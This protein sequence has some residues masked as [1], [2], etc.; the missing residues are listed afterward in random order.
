MTDSIP[1]LTH[2]RSA[3]PTTLSITPYCSDIVDR[4]TPD[5]AYSAVNNGRR[6]RKGDTTS[7]SSLRRFASKTSVSSAIDK[8]KLSNLRKENDGKWK[9]WVTVAIF[10]LIVVSLVVYAHVVYYNH[11]G[12]A[13]RSY[14]YRTFLIDTP[15]TFQSAFLKRRQADCFY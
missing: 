15:H 13:S 9:L 4:L 12:E 7:M 6:R 3:N 5:P 8:M 10:F 11:I 1:F 2:K 14:S